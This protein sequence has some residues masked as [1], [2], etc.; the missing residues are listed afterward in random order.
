MSKL[1]RSLSAARKDRR[2][3]TLT[4]AIAAV[5]RITSSNSRST[6]IPSSRSNRIMA[7]EA[8]YLHFI[9]KLGY[10]NFLIA[11]M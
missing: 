1:S 6:T 4:S 7:W 10:E 9:K 11:M 2:S 3:S 8:Q 5:C